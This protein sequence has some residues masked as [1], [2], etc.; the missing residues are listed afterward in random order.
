[1]S[2][3]C[4]YLLFIFRNSSQQ[5]KKTEPNPLQVYLLKLPFTYIRLILSTKV[6][7]VSIGSIGL[8]S[9]NY[10]IIIIIIININ[11]IN[12]LL[13]LLLIT[14]SWGLPVNNN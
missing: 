9:L 5:E 6:S 11:H 4:I 7:K 13:H 10:I 3:V 12:Y 1:M 2:T 8:T 14:L